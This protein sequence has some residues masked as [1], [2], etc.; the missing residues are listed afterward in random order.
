[1]VRLTSNISEDMWPRRKS[2]TRVGM[3][4]VQENEARKIVNINWPNDKEATKVGFANLLRGELL[5]SKMVPEDVFEEVVG[6]MGVAINAATE[7]SQCVEAFC[8]ALT[9]LRSHT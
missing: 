5:N 3:S 1:M 2:S 6:A 4:T 7:K 9:D 8:N